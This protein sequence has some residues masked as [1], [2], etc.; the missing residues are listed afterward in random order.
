M[1][2]FIQHTTELAYSEPVTETVM[3]V[4]MMPLHDRHQ[5][6]RAFR[7]D[8]APRATAYEHADWLDNRVHLFSILPGHDRV[9]IAARSVVQTEPRHPPFHELMTATVGQPDLS[10]LDLLRF[11][12]PIFQT[13]ALFGLASALGLPQLGTPG[14]LVERVT[15]S[16]VDHISYQ[17]GITTSAT[18][19]DQVLEHKAGVCQDLAHVQI[20]LLRANGIPA[21]YVSGYF[22]RPD[23]AAEIESH[24]WC[25]AHLA[26]H[27]WVALDPTHRCVAGGGHV[28][29]ARG[30]DFSDV[31]PNRGVYKGT[32]SERLAVRVK[33]REST[34]RPEGLLA[35]D[36]S[37]V[38]AIAEAIMPARRPHREEIEYQQAQQQQ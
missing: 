13:D 19:I 25:E 9:L 22:Y 5:V 33:I 29:V 17:K 1:L 36:L 3:E 35:L 27:G 23:G 4:R 37:E 7:L 26:E 30:R 32:A 14:A 31:P 15:T 34:E 10:Q 38:D 20:G 21:R 18:A 12:G 28:A 11:H 6:L 16:L 2:L 8:V 24:A